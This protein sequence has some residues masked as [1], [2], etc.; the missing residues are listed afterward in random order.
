MYVWTWVLKSY[1]EGQKDQELGSN[2]RGWKKPTFN[3]FSSH[4][5]RN[6]EIIQEKIQFYGNSMDGVA[7][8]IADNCKVNEWMVKKTKKAVIVRLPHTFLKYAKS[9]IENSI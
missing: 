8:L 6:V 4:M 1:F 9:V 2:G 3:I 5:E 7:G